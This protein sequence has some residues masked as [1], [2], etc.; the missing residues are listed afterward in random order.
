M[1]ITKEVLSKARII[2]E[3]KE[4]EIRVLAAKHTDKPRVAGFIDGF[5]MDGFFVTALYE[6]K[7]GWQ[8]SG[9]TVTDKDG[10]YRSISRNGKTGHKAYDLRPH[11]D[12]YGRY[13]LTDS[14]LNGEQEYF[15][16]PLYDV[17]REVE[18]NKKKKREAEKRAKT[19]NLMALVEKKG[20]PKDFD[21]FCKKSLAVG[22]EYVFL[23]SGNKTGY[24]TSCK[25][26]V[27]FKGMKMPRHKVEGRCPVCGRKV[28]FLNPNRF[29]YDE[30][31]FDTGFT[32]LIQKLSQDRLVFRFFNTTRKFKK[33]SLKDPEINTSELV[34]RFVSLEDGKLEKENFSRLTN[35]SDWEKGIIQTGVFYYRHEIEHYGKGNVYTRG[36]KTALKNSDFKYSGLGDILP[37][38]QEI[39]EKK[40][41]NIFAYDYLLDRY[42]NFPAIEIICKN[43]MW[44]VIDSMMSYAWGWGYF[45]K[46]FNMDAKTPWDFLK[47][48]KKLYKER[49]VGKRLSTKKIRLLSAFPDIKDDEL[50]L[51]DNGDADCSGEINALTEIRK[52]TTFHKAIKYLVKQ[53][54][55]GKVDSAY[56]TLWADYLTM[57]EQ[58]HLNLENHTWY[59]YD[60]K[61]TMVVFPKNLVTAHNDEIVLSKETE[62]E[63]LKKQRLEKLEKLDS[64]IDEV[65]KKYDFKEGTEYQI[66]APRDGYE[67]IREGQIQHICVGNI[68]MGYIEKMADGKTTILFLRKQTEPDKPFVTMEVTN[69][70]VVQ[71]RGY[72]NENPDADVWAFVKKFKQAKKLA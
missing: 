35:A 26:D 40:D 58:P 64:V 54:K 50:E 53:G 10:R 37:L 62:D 51:L 23:N 60:M 39:A 38:V 27:S 22:N 31:A 24:C 41:S 47:V 57:A 20:L 13:E 3:G 11:I 28:I 49:I 61:N 32:L 68:H 5:V 25:C 18:E 2:A 9:V 8:L 44:G 7:A 21:S 43:K 48:S 6:E 52:F 67:I 36:L 69:G 4:E 12:W 59:H 71:V 46:I 17:R 30:I 33:S 72:R 15:G 55:Q 19:D 56:I 42:G 1:N 63:R 65:H 45:R 34:R 29:K 14:Y 66:Q 70:S 16:K